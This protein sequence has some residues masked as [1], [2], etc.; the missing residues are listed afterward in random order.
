[1]QNLSVLILP[2]FSITYAASPPRKTQENHFVSGE[3]FVSYTVSDPYLL[4][5]VTHFS[6]VNL[7]AAIS[8]QLNMKLYKKKELHSVCSDNLL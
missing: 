6:S 3:S 4:F 5:L 7:A 2:C 1:M 8:T